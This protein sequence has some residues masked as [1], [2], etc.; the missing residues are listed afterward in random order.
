MESMGA[1]AYLSGSLGL[2]V[3]CVIRTHC[4]RGLAVGNFYPGHGVGMGFYA[5]GQFQKGNV[6]SMSC[7][8]RRGALQ[9]PRRFGS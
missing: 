9:Y 4:G 1:V 7:V 2:R 6:C 5:V 8:R 3:Q